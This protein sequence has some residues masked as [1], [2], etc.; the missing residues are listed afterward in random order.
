[1]RK[2]PA[3][4]RKSSMEYSQEIGEAVCHE[5]ATQDK[6]LK[7][8]C[9]EHIDAGEEWPSHSLI[10]RWRFRHPEFDE[11]YLA[12]RETQKEVIL[13]STMDI[14]DDDDVDIQ[15]GKLRTDVRFRMLHYLTPKGQTAQVEDKG[16]EGLAP[17][18]EQMDKHQR[19]Y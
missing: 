12:A 11:M 2:T 15:R 3:F 19:E 7:K 17:T 14:A 1:M 13:D 10:Y 5:I 16:Y 4:G 8:I 18:A 9:Q 6:S